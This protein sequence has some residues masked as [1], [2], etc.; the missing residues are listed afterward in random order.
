[1]EYVFSTYMGG[2][3]NR[4]FQ[5]AV[6]YAYS[7]KHNKECVIATNYYQENLQ[8]KLHSDK[9]LSTIFTKVKKDS[10]QPNYRINEPGH[11]SIS[12]VELPVYPGNILLFGYFQC[13]KYFREY[14]EEIKSILVFPEIN[15][16][17]KENSIFLHVRRGDYTN[18]KI[19]GGYNY[20]LYYKNALEYMK[21]NILFS[22]KYSVL[23]IYV[24]SDDIQF[25]KEWD[26]FQEYP[27]FEFS[28]P[29]LNEVETIKFMSLCDKGGIGANSTFSWWGGY[30]N[31]FPDKTM[32]FPNKWFFAHP[33]DKYEN[34]IAFDGSIRL[35]CI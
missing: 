17:P 28:F 13:E 14:R 25:C 21:N 20:R 4:L 9:Y 30:L 27:E 19:H 6:S 22:N 8:G 3:G 2:L 26:L 12:Y 1:M 11:K 23:N 35:D 7:K 16:I 31:N 32:I 15:E 29:N 33:H 5:F 18:K 34:D 24:F 10:F